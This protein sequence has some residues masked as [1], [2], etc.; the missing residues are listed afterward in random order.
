[1]SASGLS[2]CINISARAV[3][4]R[5]GADSPRGK[6]VARVGRA[7]QESV[8]PEANAATAHIC[9]ASLENMMS[10]DEENSAS[11]EDLGGH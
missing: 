2:L 8:N 5:A 11:T 4:V 9:K 7:R 1:M 3:A 6:G 10:H